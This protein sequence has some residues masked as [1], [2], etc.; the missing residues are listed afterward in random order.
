MKKKILYLLLSFIFVISF[1]CKD[2]LTVKPEGYV[3]ADQAFENADDAI[4]AVAGLYGLMQ[5]LVDQIYLAGEAQGDLVVAARGA[6]KYISEIAQNRVTPQNPYTDYTNFY[7]LIVACNNALTG[8]GNI[9]KI[10]RVSYSWEKYNFDVAEIKYIRAWTYLQLVKIWEDVPYISTSITSV[11]QI[12]MVAPEKSDVILRGI[13]KD[14]TENF[15]QLQIARVP[16]TSSI[17]DTNTSRAQFTAQAARFLLSDIYL[18]LGDLTKSYETILPMLPFGERDFGVQRGIAVSLSAR[19]W[20][21]KI[22]GYQ[23]DALYPEW[24]LYIDFDGSKGQKNSL[25]RWTNNKNGGIYALKPSANAIKNWDNTPMMLLTYQI[26][27]RGLYFNYLYPS[28]FN[29]VSDS[30]GY[31]VQGC[32]SDSTRGKGFSYNIDGQDTL[33]FKYLL[34]TRY[35]ARSILQGNPHS[36]DDAQFL[37]YRTGPYFLKTIEMLNNMGMPYQALQYLNGRDL[38]DVTS[39][40]NRVWCMPF[41][42][43]PKRADPVVQM[44]RFI[45]EE[46][47]LEGAFEGLR[48]FDLVR[49]AK[50]PG[51]ENWIGE[52]VSKKYP[53][54]QREAIKARLSNRAYWHFPYY[55][56]NVITNKLLQQKQGY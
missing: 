34:N 38:P 15:S 13:L 52:Y 12:T 3:L 14:A 51:Y 39:T 53:A 26:T 42:F 37:L 41:K 33:I 20:Y 4:S 19:F 21:E 9:L 2:Y 50:R 16:S 6:D 56:K 44:N 40:R 45:L 24:G 49:F 30:E 17:I 36:N 43:D 22:N 5:P 46:M 48:W 25:Q 28:G 10:D 47:A 55:Y 18:H 27:N 11:D 35:V 7:K 1:S 31:P 32:P 54:N 8:V 29:Y 23:V